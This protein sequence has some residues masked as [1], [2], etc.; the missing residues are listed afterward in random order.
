MYEIHLSLTDL[1]VTFTFIHSI[2]NKFDFNMLDSVNVYWSISKNIY[3]LCTYIW[4]YVSLLRLLTEC[5]HWSGLQVCLVQLSA[6]FYVSDYNHFGT[7]KDNGLKINSLPLTIVSA[8][9]TPCKM[10]FCQKW[11]LK[12]LGFFFIKKESTIIFHCFE[13]HGSPT[14]VITLKLISNMA[15]LISLNESLS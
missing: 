15:N 4:Y 6:W 2:H 13:N 8:K 11:V 14:R 10:A 9:E 3:I 5:S 7:L 1:N 12:I